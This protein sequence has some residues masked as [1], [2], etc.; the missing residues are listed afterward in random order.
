MPITAPA[1][2]TGGYTE[3]RSWDEVA[4]TAVQTLIK[5]SESGRVFLQSFADATVTAL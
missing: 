1:K 2:P 4:N 5:Q 3:W